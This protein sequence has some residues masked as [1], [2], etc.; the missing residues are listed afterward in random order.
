MRLSIGVKIWGL[1]LLPVVALGVVSLLTVL[2]TQAVWSQSERGLQQAGSLSQLSAWV[3]EVQKERGLTLTTTLAGSDRA[4][5]QTQRAVVDAKYTDADLSGVLATLRAASDSGASEA[6]FAVFDRYSDLIAR[7]LDRF[8][9]VSREPAPTDLRDQFLVWYQLELA[10]ERAAAFR[11]WTSGLL[12]RN[13][14]VSSAEL[15]ETN[16]LR[17]EFLVI[18]EMTS[19]RLSEADA[20]LWAAYLAGPDW[21]AIGQKSAVLFTPVPAA[22]FGIDATPY[23]QLATTTVT[24]IQTLAQ[25][26]QKSAQEK[27]TASVASSRV[28]YWFQMI[29]L[30]VVLSLVVGMG[31]HILRSIQRPL[32]RVL[33]SLEEL[34][35][36][37]GD[38]TVQ[39]PDG[40]DDE[41]GDLSRYFNLFVIRLR[42]LLESLKQE[43][44]KVAAISAVLVEETSQSASSTSQISSSGAMVVQ[45]SQVQL[46]A[47]QRAKDVVDRF[48][49][50]IRQIDETTAEMR[51]Q[52]QSA[53]SGVEEIA[54]SLE[55]TTTL[56]DRT[57]Q[58]AEK[59]AEASASGSDSVLNLSQ[60]VDVVANLAENIGEMTSLI[61]DIAGQTNLLSMNAAIEAAHA[62][63]AGKGFAVVAEEIRRLAE[64]SSVGANTIQKTVKQVQSGIMQTRDLTQITVKAFDILKDEINGLQKASRE[65]SASMEEQGQANRSVLVSVGEVSR[66]ADNTSQALAEQSQ[67]GV[68]VLKLLD[69]LGNASERN[70][71]ASMGQV[72]GLLQIDA[73]S[74]QLN[75]IAVDLETSS[76]RILVDFGQFKTD[77]G[78]IDLNKAVHAHE[79]WKIRLADHLSG[80]KPLDVPLEKVAKDDQCALGE[81]IHHEGK[82]HASTPGF[83]VLV[84]SHAEFHRIAAEVARNGDS[85][86]AAKLLAPNSPFGRASKATIGHIKK[87]Q[88]RLHS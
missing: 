29:L 5:I 39:I 16:R 54:A 46:L 11:G 7:T 30:V 23:F 20:A 35:Q 81:W 14:S 43:A 77:L 1:I 71:E 56:S 28:T 52:M 26:A 19:A 63:E 68:E 80:K 50:Q 57:R 67:Q 72:V 44:G 17:Y 66:L 2:A 51:S 53:A 69:D 48:V 22:G 62:G 78:T 40:P 83:D 60:T 25:A 87:L 61:A 41:I 88:L 24:A 85:V 38:L 49:K 70:R 73:A 36:G 21:E 58:S 4:P 34:S 47:H 59:A 18:M 65:L 13:T 9:V 55:T 75:A 74:R 32:K 82:E 84:S 15:T 27:A 37:A 64:T 79:Q 12:A 42:E 33:V 3:L 31:W 76:T 10:K 8:G 6:A 86:N 45:N